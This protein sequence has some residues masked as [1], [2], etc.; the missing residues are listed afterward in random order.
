MKDENQLYELAVHVNP[1]IEDTKVPEV[2]ATI[3]SYITANGGTIIYAKELEKIRLSYEINHFK[4][5]FFGYFHFTME[6]A[7]GLIHINEQLKANPDVF[8]YLVIKTI[9]DAEKSKAAARQ[10]RIRIKDAERKESVKVP[11]PENKELDK[12]L[13]SI[14]EKL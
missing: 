12:Q 2:R 10:H 7:E 8:R 6:D 9:S 14:I 11:A 13:E 1:D 4:N 5:S 3:E